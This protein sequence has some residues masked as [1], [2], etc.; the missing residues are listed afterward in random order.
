MA[1]IFPPAKQRPA[2]LAFA[3]ACCTRPDKLR[4]DECGDWTIWG[5]NG[6]VY[7]VPVELDAHGKW[8]F[9]LTGAAKIGYQF[10][11]SCDSPTGWTWAKK[12]LKVSRCTQDGDAE[13]AF[14]LDRLP[15]Q[16]EASEVRAVLG[17]PKRVEYSEETLAAKRA[18]F[19]TVS[20]KKLIL[21]PVT[22][23]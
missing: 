4:R 5:N 8:V 23:A 21:P 22:A 12:R 20:K 3:E 16:S 18:R 15:T 6:H 9:P 2:L 1:D 14:I 13:G 7:A 17:I 11:V 10:M 19:S